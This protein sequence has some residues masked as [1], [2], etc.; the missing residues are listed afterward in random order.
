MGGIFK[1]KQNFSLAQNFSST[2]EARGRALSV[3]SRKNL[4][5]IIYST[6]S[7]LHIVNWHCLLGLYHW[8]LLSLHRRANLIGTAV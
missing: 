8:A 5:S 3:T 4:Q 2:T 7:L 1:Y 6:Q